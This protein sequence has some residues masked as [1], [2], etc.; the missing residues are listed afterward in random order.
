MRRKTTGSRFTKEPSV[1]DAEQASPSPPQ[2][3]DPNYGETIARVEKAFPGLLDHEDQ[4]FTQRCVMRILAGEEQARKATPPPEQV[5][6]RRDGDVTSAKCEDRGCEEVGEEVAPPAYKPPETE[7]VREWA[8]DWIYFVEV[9]LVSALLFLLRLWMPQILHRLNYWY[10]TRSWQPSDLWDL[11]FAFLGVQSQILY[12]LNGMIATLESNEF[13]VAASL[14]WL[15]FILYLRPIRYKRIG[16]PDIGAEVN[17]I[18]AVHAIDLEL[19]SHLMLKTMLS[20]KTKFHADNVRYAAVQWVRLNRKGWSEIQTL[21]Q[22]TR[23]VG[24]CMELTPCESALFQYW[25]VDGVLESMR[26]VTR[27][28]K[29][30]LLPAGGRMDL[31]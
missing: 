20:S 1:K 21:E 16:F 22:V 14:V 5:D 28:V 6:D 3:V 11:N 17:R 18:A 4:A 25:E 13:A 23:S 19:L 30:G 15:G 29:E 27:W 8:F 24:V 2:Q 12:D 7:G 31:A 9:F 26:G 10:N